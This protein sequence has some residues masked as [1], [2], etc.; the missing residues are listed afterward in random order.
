M[1]EEKNTTQDVESQATGNE[2][3]PTPT[4]NG[5]TAQDQAP[6]AGDNPLAPEETRLLQEKAAKA[7]ENWDLYLRSKAELENYRRRATR[8]RQEAV[9]YAAQGVVEKLLPVL[10]SFEK[11]L[12]ASQN[13]DAASIASLQEGVAMVHGQLRSALTDSGVEEIDATGQVFDPNVHEAV[14]QHETS[15]VPEG[16]VLHQVR[17]G[18]KLH[19]R[20]VRPAT[21]VVAKAPSAS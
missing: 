14:A 15:E 12:E 8:E 10:D 9:R 4:A 19:E 7:E 6:T 17:K 5:S 13:G 18:Y 2:A 11:A 16:Q 21:V 20:L 1:T 3:D